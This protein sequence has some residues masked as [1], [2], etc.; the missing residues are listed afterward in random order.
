MQGMAFECPLERN[1]CSPARALQRAQ[2]A[3]GQR[4]LR[5]APP[6]YSMKPS[7][8]IGDFQFT[9][10]SW[11]IA[12]GR[13]SSA[14]SNCGAC[15]TENLK[16]TLAGTGSVSW[17]VQGTGKGG[18]SGVPCPSANK[19]PRQVAS[20]GPNEKRKL[21]DQCD[22]PM[23]IRHPL[24]WVSRFHDAAAARRQSHGATG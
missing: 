7:E 23:G 20:T 3:F 21:R 10:S 24:S 5:T 1:R 15:A 12:P 16:P 8:A 4:L 22:D 19:R 6:R 18:E 17:F 13:R 2:R 14:S 11:S 9:D